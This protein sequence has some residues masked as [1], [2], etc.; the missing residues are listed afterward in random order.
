MPINITAQTH[1]AACQAK[2]NAMLISS[3]ASI[4]TLMENRILPRSCVAAVTGSTI[5][6]QLDSPSREYT[7]IPQIFI[8]A[9]KYPKPT[10]ISIKISITSCGRLESNS[11]VEAP[12]MPIS[13][14][15]S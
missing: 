15:T 13:D 8:A 5:I 9:K 11:A 3:A 2:K 6:S 4:V 10:T 14:A 12:L 1:H 7:V